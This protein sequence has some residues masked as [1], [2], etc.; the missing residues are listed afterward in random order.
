MAENV[1]DLRPLL[2]PKSIVVIGASE[3][4]TRIGGRPLQLAREYGF[5]GSVYAVNPKYQTVQG[6]PCFPDIDA[7]PEAPE[8][9]ILAIGARDVLPT[10]ESCAVKGIKAA[11]IFAGGFAELGTPEGAGLQRK[12]TGLADRTGLLIAGP[13]AIGLVNVRANNY[14]TFMTA[15]LE[16]RPTPGDV[17]LVAQSGG[18]CI[19]VYNTTHRRGVGFNYIINT[20]NEAA[21][22]YD[23][24]LR[25]VAADPQTKVVAGYI[26]GLD[27]GPEFVDALKDLRQRDIPVVLYKVGETDAGADAAASHTARLAGNHAVF[28]M[29]LSQLGAMYAHDM[30][31]LAELTYLCRYAKKSSGKR[32][33]ILTTSGAFAA[34]LT[35]QLVGQG[36]EVPTLSDDLQ[37][38]LK[39]HLP[40]I[41]ITGNPVDITANVVNSPDGFEEA[42]RLLL[43]S[44]EVDSVILF[45]TSNLIDKLSGAITRNAWSSGKL[46]AVMVTGNAATEN[47]IESSGSPVF[48][49][50]G[51]G[52]LALGTFAKWKMTAGTTPATEIN[53]LLK[54]NRIISEAIRSG[55]ATLNESEAK[56]LMA[57]FGIEVTREL[58]VTT[59]EQAAA[60]AAGTT[61]PVVMKVLS[62]DITHKTEVGGVRLNL[63]SPEEVI[64]A[65][66]G[67]Q[68]NV[69]RLAPKAKIDGVTLQRQ[70]VGG[71][72]IL[73]SARRDPLFGPVLSVALGGTMTELLADISQRLLPVDK[74]TAHLMLREL[75]MFPLLDGFRGAPQADIEALADVI[76]KVSNLVMEVGED[77]EELE[78]NPV[79]ARSKQVG[80]AIAVDGVVKLKGDNS[81]L[82]AA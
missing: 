52:S 66:L 6:F 27:R 17:A 5:Q 48:H 16:A 2:S 18:A 54:P 77:L 11:V 75:R 33:G 9:A 20:G 10:L 62:S 12:L 43:A 28:R 81:K 29:A 41:A 45:S 15:M 3:E 65:F 56:K 79:I 80:G 8:L 21:I 13:N 44:D 14:A 37:A 22:R 7:L 64:E 49:D 60:A 31:Q 40:S 4:V 74:T 63:R 73:V 42:L 72:E 82:E 47:D 57:E 26:E 58:L 23:E 34:I 61:F 55:R 38:K 46:L 78:I 1:R 50:T 53:A 51:R 25:Y 67:I 71:V 24:Y 76:Q 70:E 19:A 30:E 59:P 69:A 39:P 35:D 68:S 32:V 36:L